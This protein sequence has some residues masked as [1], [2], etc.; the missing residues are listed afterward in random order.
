MKKAK[1]TLPSGSL[2]VSY[3]T[4]GCDLPK[5]IREVVAG[6]NVLVWFS[7]SLA[8]NDHGLPVVA[9]EWDVD[10]IG[11]VQKGLADAQ[12]K[13][14]HLVCIG[15]WNAPHPDTSFT[16]RQWFEAWEKCCLLYTSDAADE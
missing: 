4:R 11:Q 12:L 6:V 3:V 5:I 1:R 9:F 16:G 8:K 13:T 15:G 2:I 7:S 10:F 14:T